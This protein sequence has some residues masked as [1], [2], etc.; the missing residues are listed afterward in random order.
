MQNQTEQRSFET[1]MAVIRITSMLLAVYW[2]AIFIATHLPGRALPSVGS[3]K[4]YH[5]VAFGG[6]G[7][8]LSWAMWL[9]VRDLRVHAVLVLT[10]SILYA[11]FDEW[12]QQFVVG[13]HPDMLDAV[14]DAIGALAGWCAFQT[15]RM[16]LSKL[17]LNG[18]NDKIREAP[19]A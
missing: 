3:D 17:H 18:L 11:C 15:A 9:R 7:L 16:I 19:Q 6:L 14:A 4:F 12:S 10:V 5:L 2:L 8:L 1:V 13:R